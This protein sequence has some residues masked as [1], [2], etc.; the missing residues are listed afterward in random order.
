M[1]NPPEELSV[2]LG[3]DLEGRAG[4]RGARA[5]FGLTVAFFLHGSAARGQLC[6]EPA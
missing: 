1:S 6:G 2:R 4:S 5:L 3:S